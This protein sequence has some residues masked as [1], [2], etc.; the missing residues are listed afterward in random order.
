MTET[1]P[2]VKPAP[3]E[4]EGTLIAFHV[5]KGQGFV[6]PD[7]GPPDILVRR[8]ILIAA[9]VTGIP[10]IGSRFRCLTEETEK[11]LYALRVLY[12]SNEKPVMPSQ[13]PEEMTVILY[14]PARYGL[15]KTARGGQVLLLPSTVKEANIETVG[16]DEKLRVWYRPSERGFLATKI[17]LAARRPRLLAIK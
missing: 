12:V 5:D 4:I 17:E 11:G 7:G 8:G 9:G 15:L 2:S 6:T 3:K 1:V 16:K 14:N 10:P 13:G